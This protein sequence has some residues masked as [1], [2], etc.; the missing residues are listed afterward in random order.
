MIEKTQYINL[1]S[2]G[3]PRWFLLIAQDDNWLAVIWCDGRGGVLSGIVAFCDWNSI[4]QFD[5]W[6]K[7]AHWFSCHRGT[8]EASGWRLRSICWPWSIGRGVF[9]SRKTKEWTPWSD[10]KWSVRTMGEAI[11]DGPLEWEESCRIASLL[12]DFNNCV[13]ESWNSAMSVG[14]GKQIR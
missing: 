3:E 6:R 14:A 2:C 8:N 5:W 1:R 9:Q 13:E 11:T 12:R 4:D 10:G 7:E